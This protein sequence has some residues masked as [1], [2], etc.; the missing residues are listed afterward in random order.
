MIKRVGVTLA[1]LV[2]VVLAVIIGAMPAS[3]GS[4]AGGGPGTPAFTFEPLQEPPFPP[5]RLTATAGSSFEVD[6]SWIAPE[7]PP[8][9][10]GYDVYVG[11]SLGGERGPVNSAIITGTRFTV[12]GLSE[13]TGYYFVVTA[14]DRAGHE[15]GPS[16]EA[17]A[18][19]PYVPLPPGPSTG[20][21]GNSVPPWLIIVPLAVIG[22]AI[23]A[24]VVWRRR[25]RSV[26]EPSIRAVPHVG[27]PGVV[28]IHATGTHA[29]HIV[30]IVPHPDVS[31]TTIEEP[32]PR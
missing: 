24:L 23:T 11:I 30:R 6:L 16:N 14:V 29:A 26:P 1:S 10:I 7:T 22:A 31:I 32:P 19:T 3:A 27:P 2:V 15:S 13:G 12:T 28:S 18:N 9:V 17:L 5:T 21:T 25:S 8:P 4:V 20:P